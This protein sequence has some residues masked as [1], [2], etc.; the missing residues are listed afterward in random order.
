[1]IN[2]IVSFA[3][4]QRV[5]VL[6]LT[7]IL[8]AVGFYSFTQLPIEAYP[9]VMNTQ[10]Q[11]ITQWPG[12]AAEEVEQLVTIPLETSVNGIPKVQSIRSRSLFGLSVVYLTFN[13]GVD[14]YFAHNA[15]FQAINQASLPSGLQ[16]TLSP[17]ASATGEIFRYVLTGA[18]PMELKTIEDWVLEREFKSIP[19][20]A[21]VNSFGGPIRQYQ[22]LIDPGRLKAFDVTLKDVTDALANANANAG[23]SFVELGSEEYVVRG[24]GQFHDEHDIE[25]VVVTA[26]SGT[27]LRISDVATVRIGIQPRLG[28]VGWTEEPHF[29]DHDDAVEGIILLLRGENPG[30]VLERIHD[31]IKALNN[32]ILPPGVKVH[33]VVDRTTLVHT[34]TDT[35]EHNL[36][37]GVILVVG[38]LFLFLLNV[39][40]SVIVALTIP[41]GL[42]FAFMLMN[43]IHV[44][45]NLL[46][47][48]AID[49][50]VIVNGTVILVENVY[51]R[52]GQVKGHPDVIHVIL[53]AIGEVESEIFYTTLII[54]L[55]YV[56]L[57]TMQSVEGKMF[58]PMAFT[59][60]LALIG[61]LIMALVV[62]PVLCYFAFRKGVH[63]RE[64]KLE[65]SMRERYVKS[66]HWCFDNAIT[67]VSAGLGICVLGAV[68]LPGLGTEF[69]PHLDEGN[70]WIRATMPTTISYT[71]AAKLMSQFRLKMGSYQPTRVVVSQLGR[72]DDGTDASGFYNAEFLVDLK[73]YSEWTQF[74]TKPELI[75]KMTAD[76]N[77]MPGVSWNFSQNIE[78]NVE[79]AVTGVKGELAV[80]LFGD[81]LDV[82]EKKATEIQDVLSKIRGI[83]DLS[84][85]TETGEPQ[86]TISVDRVKMARY[87]LNSQDI[88]DVVE[89]AIGG[90][91]VT[92]LIEGERRFDVVAR[93]NE[94]SRQDLSKISNIVVSTSEGQRIPLSQLAD[95]KAKRGA[96]F[97]Y[98]EANRRFIAI[99]FGVRDRDLGGAVEEAQKKVKAVVKLPSGYTTQW[100][101]E[102][103]S[104][105]RAGARLLVILPATL[106]A[107]FLVLYTMFNRVSRAAIVMMNVLLSFTGAVV[108]LHY[109]G[110]ALS[111]S[112]AVGFIAL[113]GVAVQNGVIMVSSFDHLQKH[114]QSF[115]DAILD[116]AA[117]RLRPVLMTVLLATIGLVPAAL[118]TGIGSDVQK[119][120]AIAIIGG[121]LL[122]GSIGTL[123]VLPMLY[124]LFARALPQNFV[125]PEQLEN[126]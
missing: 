104:M 5:L 19:G 23:G 40:A 25:N 54:I 45:A 83:T 46:S 21:D 22:V 118:S 123:Y 26:H 62:A 9:D 101:G 12:H 100:G 27:P 52:M 29:E 106:L 55:G 42:L 56:P 30:P 8:L 17:I 59:I 84:T 125:D 65:T 97:V 37:E 73:P 78:D 119:P 82:L 67:V 121:L 124:R 87:G 120:L 24:Q 13:D 81:D 111:V 48:G 72:P 74:R 4:Q 16:P 117:T 112:A 86:I 66:L 75:K 79:E 33:P 94:E 96:S 107:I 113:F 70:L 110:Y 34:T 71:Q 41:F 91:T 105:Q 18:S 10:V 98:R 61:S 57:F 102:F 85:F 103:E 53:S 20:V 116:G 109:T 58:S 14:D 7:A 31:K 93:L 43:W 6:I 35:V 49:F 3:I 90:K 36:V 95:V 60:G 44:P 63:Y 108:A 50:G 88:Q 2:R 64:A 122:G 39:R 69:L 68:M 32:G 92:Q 89:T 38:V 11:V 115:R 77:E 80:K 99:K 76:L 1:M 15:V 114:G 28:K 126:S 51:R 47:L